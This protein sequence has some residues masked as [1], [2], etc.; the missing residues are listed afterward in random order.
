ML[1]PATAPQ[2]IAAIDEAVDMAFAG[3]VSGIVTNP[4]QKE[5]LYAAGFRHQGH[6]D[7]LAHRSRPAR[8]PRRRR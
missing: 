3:E 1:D 4:I 2:V 8:P 6:T 7:Y 5:A